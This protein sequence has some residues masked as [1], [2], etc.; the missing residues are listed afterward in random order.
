[1]NI[2]SILLA[3]VAIICWGSSDFLAAHAT[4]NTNSMK[5]FFWS[6][7]VGLCLYALVFLLF[8]RNIPAISLL[9][10]VYIFAMTIIVILGFL[11]FYKGFQ[12]GKVGVISPIVNAWS[13]VTILVAITL[14]G[15][16]LTFLTGIAITIVLIGAILSSF[17]IYDIINLK[18]QN[19]AAGV[20]FAIIAMVLFG[21][22]FSILDPLVASLGFLL[23]ILLQK[24]IQVPMTGLF[25]KIS[26]I[27]LSFP[28]IVA[29]P[30]LLVGVFE[31]GGLM[32]YN[33]AISSELTSIIAPLVASA[34]LIAAFWARIFLKEKLEINQWIGAIVIVIGIAILSTL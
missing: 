4:R 25:A 11:S 9:E 12:V 27:N 28:R 29:F 24:L 7:V 26:N 5:T 19:I 2:I 14:L 23:P 22:A 8:F 30:I 21:I 20:F 31:F 32:A 17:K 18:F 3:L 34:P 1:M 33:L 10:W 16:S 13:I 6:Q 15:E